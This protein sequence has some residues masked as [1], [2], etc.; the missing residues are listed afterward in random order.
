M[1][2]IK[3]FIAG[4]AL[5]ATV[6]PV[7]YLILY[8][9]I[10]AVRNL[11][12]QFIPLYMPLVWGVWNIGYFYLADKYPVKDRNKRYFLIGC[13]LGLIWALFA[14][15]ILELPELFGIPISKYVFIFIVPLF[16]GLIWMTAV[17]YFNDLLD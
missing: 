10:G 4:L 15:F 14:V 8:L 9:N 6:L 1:K 13:P 5:P 12:L 16:F 11:P 7:V 17:K 2:Y 3:A